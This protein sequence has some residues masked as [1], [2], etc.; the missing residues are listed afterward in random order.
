[1]RSA[2]VL[3]LSCSE[4][5]CGETTGWYSWRLLRV[6]PS[7]LPQRVP[8]R[9]RLQRDVEEGVLWTGTVRRRPRGTRK[10]PPRARHHLRV[11]VQILSSH[12]SEWTGEIHK[13]L[14]G[15]IF[16]TIYWCVRLSS[17]VWAP[18]EVFVAETKSNRLPSS[19]T[20]GTAILSEVCVLLCRQILVRPDVILRGQRVWQ[21]DNPPA[22]RPYLHLA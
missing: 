5:S 2:T 7:E 20:T 13:S 3:D 6:R 1:M 9:V 12:V 10:V 22:W 4:E 19:L 15:N 11:S 14:F 18:A 17:D 16:V 21:G 8:L